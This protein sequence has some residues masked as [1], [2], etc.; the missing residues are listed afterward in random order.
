MCQLSLIAAA[1]LLDVD[2]MVA[3]RTAPNHSYVN[4]V[5]RTMSIFNLGL[6]GVSLCRPKM[7]DSNEA[8]AKKCKSMKQVRA[9]LPRNQEFAAALSS[10]YFAFSMSSNYFQLA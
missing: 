8:L 3:A 6:Q 10:R 7:D 2:Y 4:V 9:L 5:E 1:L